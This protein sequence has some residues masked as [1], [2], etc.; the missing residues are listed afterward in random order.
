MRK[1]LV[2][3]LTAGMLLSSVAL[4]GPSKVAFGSGTAG[5]STSK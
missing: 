3:A 2:V 1:I 5:H 4:A